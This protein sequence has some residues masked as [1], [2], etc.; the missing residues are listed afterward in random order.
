MRQLWL[1]WRLRSKAPRLLHAEQLVVT[2]HRKRMLKNKGLTE[3]MSRNVASVSEL[4]R[5]NK[6]VDH[7]CEAALRLPC[8]NIYR[9]HAESKK[10]M[11][12]GCPFIC[13]ATLAART[14]RAR[15]WAADGSRTHVSIFLVQILRR[16][17]MPE[18]Q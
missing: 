2:V 13:C 11:A 14:A 10:E 7:R 12:S 6:K 5:L 8:L 9:E 4:A 15:G 17:A 16:P 3:E 1:V 18:V